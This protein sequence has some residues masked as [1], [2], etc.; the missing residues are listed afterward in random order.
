M[1]VTVFE[2][3]REFKRGK[4]RN[5]AHFLGS[6]W[7]ARK[8]RSCSSSSSTLHN[9]VARAEYVRVLERTKALDNNDAI[10]FHLSKHMKKPP[11][12]LQIGG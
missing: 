3:V 4:R 11:T 8:S 10:E 9:D 7:L 6:C 2:R 5:G 12:A 1:P